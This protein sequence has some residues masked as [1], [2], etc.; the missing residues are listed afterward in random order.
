MDAALFAQVPPKKLTLEVLLELAA[1]RNQ[2]GKS[3]LL[4][5]T[6][7]PSTWE[8]ECLRNIGVEGLVLNLD[9]ADAGALGALHGRIRDLPKPKPRSERHAAL[10]P[11]LAIGG[12]GRGGQ[13]D[14]DDDEEM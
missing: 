10:L 11:Q 8:L 7:A 9:Q 14:D 1:H 13:D 2:I 6:H 3:F 12:E 5:I 4:P